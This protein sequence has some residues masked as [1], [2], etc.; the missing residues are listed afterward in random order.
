MKRIGFLCALVSVLLMAG[1]EGLL[2]PGTTNTS[3]TSTTTST[4]STTTTSTTSTTTTSTTTTSTTTTTTVPPAQNIV[5][6]AAG[7]DHAFFLGDDGRL[8]GTGRNNEGELGVGTEQEIRTPV[9]VAENVAN[10]WAGH[11]QSFIKKTD[12]SLWATGRNGHGQL[13]VGD[14]TNRKAWT[15]VQGY[16][17][18]V[19]EVACGDAHTLFL[20]GGGSLY[21]SGT[22]LYGRLFDP[23]MADQMAPAYIREGVAAIA[24]GAGHSVLVLAGTGEV[25]TVG[26][27]NYGQ[28]GDGT[29]SNNNVPGTT[30][31]GVSQPAAGYYHTV[32]LKSDGSLWGWGYAHHGQLGLGGDYVN[33]QLLPA[34]AVSVGMN[35]AY[36]ASGSY[37]TM[38][39]YKD[40]SLWGTGSNTDSR[41][42]DGTEN[43]RNEPVRVLES[44]VSRVA[45]GDNFSIILTTDKRVMVCGS[46]YYG[47][48]GLGDTGWQTVPRYLDL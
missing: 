19:K 31:D 21:A 1:C 6:I 23:S 33:A 26:L 14:S 37:H 22:N 4:T 24:A 45:C 35:A 28:L 7:D 47:Q 20:T 5:M 32:A 10:V 39:V 43:Q 11:G 25:Q 38:I 13:G 15:Q 17:A 44:G 34:Q 40:G 27:N 46:N 12:G 2:G 30:M 8:W 29:L 36:V 9:V 18:A 42:G 3:T 48:I 16:P 41:L